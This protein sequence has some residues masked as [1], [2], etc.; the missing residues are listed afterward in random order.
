MSFDPNNPFPRGR[1]TSAPPTTPSAERDSS[2]W[3][4]VRPVP[5]TPGAIQFETNTKCGILCVYTRAEAINLAAWI[6]AVVSGEA[7]AAT[8][9]AIIT[10]PPTNPGGEP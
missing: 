2:N 7:E 10:T 8:L 6:L 5:G 4:Y 1:W 9:A 3:F